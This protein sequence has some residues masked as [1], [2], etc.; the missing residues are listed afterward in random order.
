VEVS[1]L[2]AVPRV[3]EEK[4]I[5]FRPEPAPRASFST[6]DAAAKSS[7]K[8]F[9]VIGAL[10]AV[11]V[12]G[13]IVALLKMRQP[14]KTSA[15]QS[16]FV[17]APVNASADSAP[18]ATATSKPEAQP[19]ASATAEQPVAT[20]QPP[21]NSARTKSSASDVADSAAKKSAKGSVKE[22]TKRAGQADDEQPV[23]ITV[24][25]SAGGSRIAVQK[26]QSSQSDDVQPNLSMGGGTNAGGLSMLASTPSTPAPK[27]LAHSELIP[28][29]SIRQVP[30]VYP[31]IAMARRLSGAVIVRFTVGKDGHV[32]SPKLVSGQPV[33][34]D[35]A[36]DAV[37]QWTY[38]PAVLDGQP[39]EQEI[40]VRLNF[41]P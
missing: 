26:A 36:F 32:Y 30:P 24:P 10:V 34:R 5:E 2:V 12:G 14:G 40:E 19:V 38:K 11:L 1:K 31:A 20:T 7:S 25:V 41:K 33:F 37:K 28:A 3:A 22:T 15:P 4:R 13:G 27:V 16:T 18:A 9:V 29:T 6:L 35:A 8:K 21:D 17:P 39:A 23:S